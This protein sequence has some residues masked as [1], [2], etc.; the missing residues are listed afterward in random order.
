MEARL[1]RTTVN[2]A[3]FREVNQAID[4]VSHGFAERGW[5]PEDGR[6]DF[7]CECGRAG[8]STRIQLTPEEYDRVREQDDR[9]AVAPG[10]DTP[11]IESVVQQNERFALVDKNPDAE[12]V[13]KTLPPDLRS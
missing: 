13:L 7:H 11:E 2:E 1:E 12:R 5:A 10:H 4:S 6:L 9:F 3:L 8:C